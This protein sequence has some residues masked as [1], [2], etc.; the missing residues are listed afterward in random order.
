MWYACLVLGRNGGKTFIPLDFS[1]HV[2]KGKEGKQ[3]LKAKELKAWLST[4]PG[5]GPPAYARHPER[6]KSKYNGLQV[7]EDAE[8]TMPQI[9]LR[10]H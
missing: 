7:Q 5:E 4:S 6:L 8:E 2:E 9:S 10:I 1:L 3:G